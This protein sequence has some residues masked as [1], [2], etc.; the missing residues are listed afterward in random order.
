MDLQDVLHSKN[1]RMTQLSQLSA[2]AVYNK[3]GG[4]RVGA[5]GLRT[6]N[7]CIGPEYTRP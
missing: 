7:N 5:E 6:P 2:L 1:E 3:N 4:Y